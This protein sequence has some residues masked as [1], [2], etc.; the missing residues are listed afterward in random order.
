MRHHR[1]RIISGVVVRKMVFPAPASTAETPRFPRVCSPRG[2]VRAGSE[3]KK[4][5]LPRRTSRFIPS[6]LKLF[7][8]TGESRFGFFSF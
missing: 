1:K 4:S 2:Q 5:L 7:I 6:S 8:Y 3:A